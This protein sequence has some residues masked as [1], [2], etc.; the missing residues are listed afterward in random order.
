MANLCKPITSYDFQV[1]YN[2][3]ECCTVGMICKMCGCL[4]LGCRI[5]FFLIFFLG[6]GHLV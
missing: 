6:G 1:R 5:N 3:T 2:N 4:V